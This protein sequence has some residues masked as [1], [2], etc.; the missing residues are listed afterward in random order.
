M[1]LKYFQP[2]ALNER[3]VNVNESMKTIGEK[4]GG[5]FIAG[6]VVYNLSR[7]RYGR[8]LVQSSTR[9]YGNARWLGR[10]NGKLVNV[11]NMRGSSWNLQADPSERE[12]IQNKVQEAQ[13]QLE[14]AKEALSKYRERENEL[15]ADE[16]S[17]GKQL[18]C[19]ILLVK[20]ANIDFPLAR[21]SREEG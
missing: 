7:S 2:V 3:R 16:V 11:F 9:D 6:S 1:I 10:A 4:G 18:V 15:R 8:R 14:V 20:T 5:N 12:S 17:I 19:G 13:N 21:S